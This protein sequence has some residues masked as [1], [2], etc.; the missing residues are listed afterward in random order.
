MAK[1]RFKALIKMLHI[2]DPANESDKDKLRK[3]TIFVNSFKKKCQNLYQPY[4]NVPVD[5][6]FI[7][8]KHHSR[9]RQYIANKHVKFGVKLWVLADSKNGYTFNFDIYIGKTDQTYDSKNGYTFNFDII[10]GRQTKLMN[11]V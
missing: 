6:R 3:L 9:I 11:I 4:Q 5:K 7:K 1:D 2:V 10:L 8:S